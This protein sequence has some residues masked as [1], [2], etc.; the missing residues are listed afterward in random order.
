MQGTQL[1]CATWNVHRAK[2]HD[3]RVDPGRVVAALEQAVAPERPQ[4]LAL[5]EADGECRPHASIFDM[6]DIEKRTGLEYIHGPDSR[7]GDDSDGFLGTILFLSPGMRRTW[8]DVLDLPGHCHRGAVSVEVM[9]EDRPLRIIST[10]LSLSQPLRVVQMRII[11]QYVRRRPAMQTILLGDLNEWRPWGGM[12]FNRALTG[13][14]LQGPA[15]RSFP[16]SR[17]LLPL[18]RIMTDGAGQVLDMR[19]VRTR[20][21]VEASDHLPLV[22]RVTIR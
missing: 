17:P 1:R 2:G 11:G 20:E 12:M 10:H 14:D 8:M 19:A 5:Q 7:W 3:G 13:M 18:D 4:V 21:V 15:C 22:A 16:S 6:A 9:H